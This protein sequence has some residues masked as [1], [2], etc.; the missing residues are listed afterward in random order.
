MLVER[1]Y[2][3]ERE[4]K[5]VVLEVN[6]TKQRVLVETLATAAIAAKREKSK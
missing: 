1:A 2:A 3:G 4:G 5:H 6:A